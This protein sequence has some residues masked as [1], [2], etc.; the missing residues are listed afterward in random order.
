MECQVCSWKG[1]KKGYAQHCSSEKHKLRVRIFELEQET[2]PYSD[3]HITLR[4]TREEIEDELKTK[5]K[6]MSKE[7]L[8]TYALNILLS[9]TTTELKYH[10]IQGS[11]FLR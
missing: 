6:Q 10:M 7:H 2:D 4:M 11:L 1:D 5:I 8:E 3:L 9:K